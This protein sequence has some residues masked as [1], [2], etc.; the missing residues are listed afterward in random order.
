MILSTKK[1]QL[2]K[3]M[4]EKFEYDVFLSHSSKDK[5]TVRDLAHRLTADGIKVWFDEW[6]VTAE[7]N[8]NDFIEYGLENSRVLVLAMSSNAFSSEGTALVQQTSRFRDPND[9]DR[10][11]LPILL[12]D[13]D[14]SLPLRQFYYADWRYR[15]DEQYEWIKSFIRDVS[16]TDRSEVD[17][18]E[19]EDFDSGNT[20][21]VL[22]PV[23]TLA[24]TSDETKI[25]SGSTDGIIRVWDSKNGRC[26]QILNRHRGAIHSLSLSKKDDIFASASSDGLVRVWRLENGKCISKLN[27]KNPVNAVAITPDGKKLVSGGLAASLYIWL[28]SKEVLLEALPGHTGPINSIAISNDGRLILSGSDDRTVRVWDMKLSKCTAILSGHK[29]PITS[30]VSSSDGL[31]ALSGSADKTIRIWNLKTGK[32]VAVLEGHKEWVNSIELIDDKFVVSA[33]SD[34]TIRVW[35]IEGSKCLAV[36]EGH[37]SSV[38]AVKGVP[39]SQK[40]F[41]GSQDSKLHMWNLAY[42]LNREKRSDSSTEKSEREVTKYTNAKVLLVGESGVGKS[43]L[44]HRLAHNEFVETISTDGVWATQLKLPHDANTSTN[45]REIWLWDFA[46]QSDYRLIHQL[47]M[48]ETALAVLVFN[49]QN[50]NP[51]EGLGVWDTELQQASRRHYSKLLV[52]GR[53]DRGGL[54][55]SSKS[56]DKFREERGFFKFVETSALTG[57]GCKELHEAIVDA[58][59]WNEIPHTASPRIFKLLKEEIIKL[60]DEGRVLFRISELKQQLEIRLTEENFRLEELRAVTGLLASAGLV[61][62]L[63]FGDFV[64]LQPERINSYAAAVV[65]SVRAHIDEIGCIEESKVLGGELDYQDMERLPTE[66]EHI[67]LRAMHQTFVEHSLC[68][69]ETTEKGTMLIFPSYFKRERPKKEGHQDEYVT[70]QFKAMTDDVYAT[71]IVKLHHTFAFDKDQLWRYAADFKT[72]EDKTVGLKLTKKPEGMAEITVY[73]EKGIPDDTKAIFIRYVQDHVK[74]KDENVIRIRHYIC[75]HCE[76]PFENDRAV[77]KRLE[78]GHKDVTCPICEKRFVLWDLIEEKFAS[79]EFQKFV[80]QM[81]EQAKI[82]IDN[83]SRELILVGHA[84]AITGEA[85]QIYRGFTNSD[86]GIDGEIEFKNNDGTASGVKLYLQLKSGDSYLYVRRTDNKEIFT[87][88]NPRHAKYWLSFPYPV[89]LVIRNSDGQIRWMNVTEYLKKNGIESRN[90]IFE[91]EPF[92]ALNISRMRNRLLA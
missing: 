15:D 27:H 47:F 67:I 87:I 80:R 61:W 52:A 89:M 90:I 36:F 92:T 45:E 43:G 46:G 6:E 2:P 24:I 81:E 28:V 53:C 14:I 72:Q 79:L 56:L 39:N 66:E 1:Y 65:R 23:N 49:P 33:S 62:E 86:H 35:E 32:C 5:E 91:G 57:N 4:N 83:E 48:D 63:E 84:Y 30:V 41:S 60:K 68:L 58:I 54:T 64:L 50:D 40:V 26:L 85:G 73:F 69:R 77:R 9:S 31:H 38:N 78:T 70:Y 17:D 25:I 13:C 11:F 76:E 22:K 19:P 59:A 42:F 34:R 71:L 29:G 82:L 12:E 7:E 88:R 37:Y 18:E 21:R 20:F 16:D 10:R 74:A 55:V 51:F 75:P 44:A 8:T 3:I